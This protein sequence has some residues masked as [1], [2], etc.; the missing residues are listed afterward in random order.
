MSNDEASGCDD[1][2]T[3]RRRGAGAGR[4]LGIKTRDDLAIAS[5]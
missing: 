1:D 5:R 3:T 4:V 2:A